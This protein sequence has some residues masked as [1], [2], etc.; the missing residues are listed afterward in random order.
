MIKVLRRK[1][2]FPL[3]AFG[4]LFAALFLVSAPSDA[5]ACAYTVNFGKWDGEGTMGFR[6]RFGDFTQQVPGV[7]RLES[8]FTVK[9]SSWGGSMAQNVS[10][11]ASAGKSVEVVGTYNFTLTQP[12]SKMT[13]KMYYT[14]SNWSHFID[15]YAA[16]DNTVTWSF[17]GSKFGS[18]G[19]QYA[20]RSFM[21]KV[22]GVFKKGA[23]GW[24]LEFS[25]LPEG[26]YTFRAAQMVGA[27]DMEAFNL[28]ATGMAVEFA[29]GSSPV[30]NPLPGAL[31]LLGTALAG[32][33][34]ALRRRAKTVRVEA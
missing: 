4:A 15:N 31:V 34:A 1:A 6:A 13:V 10:M 20:D 16:N 25:N 9:G 32:G 30:P 27:M 21:N 2:A 29:A 8:R 24:I 33:G 17:T 7:N 19:N 18:T 14:D 3:F 12:L 22:D 26:N 11:R 5:G 23:D 28:R